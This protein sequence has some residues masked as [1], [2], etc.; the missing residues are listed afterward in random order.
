MTPPFDYDRIAV[1]LVIRS[2]NYFF[3]FSFLLT[4]IFKTLLRT[5][6]AQ[7]FSAHYN[8]QNIN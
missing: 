1:E 2:P 8:F 7:I 6:E 3:S 5:R 4:T